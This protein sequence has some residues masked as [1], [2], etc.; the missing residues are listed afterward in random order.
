MQSAQAFMKKINELI[1]KIKIK[2]K[3]EIKSF[4]HI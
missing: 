4:E 3:Y 2:L 1:R